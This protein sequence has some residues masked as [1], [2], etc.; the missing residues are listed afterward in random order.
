MNG[1][2]LSTLRSYFVNKNEIKLVHGATS[3]YEKRIIDYM[4]ALPE[5]RIYTEDVVLSFLLNY[6]DKEIVHIDKSL[7]KYRT[8]SGSLSNAPS[9]SITRDNIILSE[10]K[11]AVN[12]VHF[13]NFNEFILDL[14][15]LSDRPLQDKINKDKISELSGFFKMQASWFDLSIVDRVIYFLKENKNRYKKWMFPRLFWLKAF[16]NLKVTY[17]ILK[18]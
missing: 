6:C 13:L 9:V 5:G 14:V 15:K 11:A 1:W 18:N 17:N 7:V 8:H 12:A 3:A 4:K 2:G 16:I 10:K